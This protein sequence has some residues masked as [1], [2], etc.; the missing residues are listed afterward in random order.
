MH[1]LRVSPNPCSATAHVV[2]GRGHCGLPGWS[3]MRFEI[4][5]IVFRIVQPVFIGLPTI[6]ESARQQE[7]LA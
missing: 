2:A 6:M 7:I 1:K 3:E 4:V 5:V